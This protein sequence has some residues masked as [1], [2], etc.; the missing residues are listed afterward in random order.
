MVYTIVFKI[1]YSITILHSYFYVYLKLQSCGKWLSVIFWPKTKSL[2][3]YSLLNV[4]K[5]TFKPLLN[6]YQN[7]V[8][9]SLIILIM[10]PQK[11][12]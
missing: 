12:C 2:I 8:K 9:H 7:F 10:F 11:S 6:S 4:F 1:F 5:N 3:L